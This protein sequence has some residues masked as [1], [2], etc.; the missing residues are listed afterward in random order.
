MIV[1]LIL[2]NIRNYRNQHYISL[3]HD[4]KISFVIGEN[5]VGKSSILS[6]LHCVLNETDI[7]K[8][9]INNDVRTQGLET[10]EP[11]IVPIFLLEKKKIKKSNFI[12]KILDVIS[13]NAWQLEVE[14][15]NQL[16]RPI[17]EKFVEHKDKL[18]ENFSDDEYFLIPIGFIKNKAS[19][20]PAT[21]LSFLESFSYVEEE[22]KSLIEEEDCP[23]WLKKYNKQEW[24]SRVLNTMREAHSY[25]YVPAEI[26]AESYSKIEG[27]LL[28]SLLGDDIHSQIGQTIRKSDIRT[29]NKHLND[30]IDKI[31][32]ILGERYHFKKPS[33]RQSQFTQRHMISKIIDA[34]FSERIL[35]RKDNDRDT[36][37]HNLSSGEKRKSLLDL[38]LAFLQNNPKRA[39]Q[40]IVFAIDEPELSLHPAACYSQ[41][42]KLRRIS[43]L[44]IQTLVTTHWYGYLPVVGEGSAVYI[45]PNQA[46]IKMI[47][48]NDYR[49]ELKNLV[50]ETKGRYF[51]TL[52]I[53]SNYDIVQSIIASLTSGNA[54]SWVVCE[55]IT[56]REYLKVYLDRLEVKNLVILP[57]SGFVTLKKIYQHLVLALEDRKTSISGKAFFLIDTDERFESITLSESISAIRIRRIH[58]VIEE[59]KVTLKKLSDTH[60]S[61]K[62]AIEDALNSD[63]YFDTLHSM[64]DDGFFELDF[65]DDDL[66][67]YP[68]RTS[69]RCIDCNAYEQLEIDNLFKIPGFKVE[70]C[71]RYVSKVN[72]DFKNLTWIDE[73]ASFLK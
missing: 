43:G 58:Q 7:N 64:K 63:V 36:N 5:G 70:F 15:F 22:I 65:F 40:D 50:A 32:S 11:F 34:Y 19:E 46:T 4:G 66:E 72:D 61:P 20:S 28:Q 59:N 60:I 13:N 62:T 42:E 14:D 31:S 41:F 67:Y 2:R 49:G 35:H 33:Q 57:V 37:I 10:R 55:G 53:K 6:A 17:V 9:D 48:L 69:G 52:E 27:E 24:S 25:I 51:D 30:F 73:I 23:S 47:R 26:T 1:G 8:L 38:A 44:E 71:K 21:Y 45:S 29:I 12:Y 54:Y 3:T 56:D 39:N 16:Q 18:Q 68:S